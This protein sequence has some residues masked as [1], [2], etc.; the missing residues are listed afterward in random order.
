MGTRTQ[1]GL[2]AAALVLVAVCAWIV[3]AQPFSEVP[4]AS[5][6]QLPPNPTSWDYTMAQY[7]QLSDGMS[8]A[9]VELIMHGGA[10][11]TSSE[12]G[13]LVTAYHTYANEDGSFVLVTFADG[14]LI[15]KMA[16][17]F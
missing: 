17:G 3:V 6:A 7:R 4:G 1:L 13:G 14:R 12:F 9:K 2:A 8:V 15:Q 11:V 5:A 16:S 10:S